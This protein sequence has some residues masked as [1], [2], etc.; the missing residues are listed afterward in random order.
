MKGTILAL[1]L[2]SL[3]VLSS[4]AW[5]QANI[6]PRP[7]QPAAALTGTIAIDLD[8][9]NQQNTILLDSIK[10]LKDLV[11]PTEF[12][13]YKTEEKTKTKDMDPSALLA[14]RNLYLKKLV[15]GA[16]TR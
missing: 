16:T 4:L 9:L 12:E 1:V 6:P 2:M 8:W 7:G 14:Y 13:L 15:M 5:A 11:S 10:L 3:V